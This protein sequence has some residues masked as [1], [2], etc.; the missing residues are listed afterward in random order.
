MNF[1]EKYNTDEVFFRGLIIGML[2]S[3]NNKITY[4]QTDKNQQVNEIFIPFFNTMVGDEPFLQDFYLSYE[5]CNGNPTFADGNYDVI[6]RGI[7]EYT[8]STI[9]ASNSTNKFVRASYNK[10]IPNGDGGAEMKTFSALL[11]PIPLTANFNVK[12]KVDT[13]LD[14]YKIQ[15]RA[16]QE[17]YKNFVYNFNF[18]GFRV[19]C[20]VVL[21]DALP[22]KQPNL[23]NMTYGS[24]QGSISGITLSF[25]L[26]VETYL[27]QIDKKSEK[28]RGNLMQ[29]GIR[30]NVDLGKTDPD[31]SGI[32]RGLNLDAFGKEI[33]P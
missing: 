23:F 26:Q 29:G 14:A 22:D 31:N 5:D 9:N 28:F 2:K 15:Q 33:L 30:V 32:L 19:P 8:G 10:E 24:T 7:I 6:P 16:Y 17:L 27:P 1:L 21:P 20:Q 11:N 3:L 13:T 25:M 12:I 18:E 4:L